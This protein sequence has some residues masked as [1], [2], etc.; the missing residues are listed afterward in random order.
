MMM[1]VLGSVAGFEVYACRGCHEGVSGVRPVN[2]QLR[3]V[4]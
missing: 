4:I 3:A 1:R 2:E